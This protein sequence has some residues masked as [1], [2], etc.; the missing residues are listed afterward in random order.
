MGRLNCSIGGGGGASFSMLASKSWI[1]MDTNPS[2]LTIST[3][4]V[5]CRCYPSVEVGENNSLQQ[6]CPSQL[7][8]YKSQKIIIKRKALPEEG[9][10]G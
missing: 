1:N 9:L 4:K 7:K 6:P 2:H 10:A 8:L 3:M 5:I